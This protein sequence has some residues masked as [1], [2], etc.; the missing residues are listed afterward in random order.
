MKMSE[1]TPFAGRTIAYSPKLAQVLGDVNAALFLCQMIHWTGKGANEDGWIYKMSDEI[2]A[3]TGLTYEQQKGCRR[4]L[5]EMLVLQERHRRRHGDIEF[6]VRLDVLEEWWLR[7]EA[8]S[9]M[10]ETPLWDWQK[11]EQGM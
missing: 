7:A 10:T 2:R 8:V 6:R 11:E 1:I 5:R 4:K 3:E 9:F